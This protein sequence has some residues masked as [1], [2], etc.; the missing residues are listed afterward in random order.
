[1][2]GSLPECRSLQYLHAWLPREARKGS[3]MPWN[4]SFRDGCEPYVVMGNQTVVL[5]KQQ[6]LLTVE[7]SF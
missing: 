7:P 1:M 5:Q 3:W 4:W 6:L 2:F